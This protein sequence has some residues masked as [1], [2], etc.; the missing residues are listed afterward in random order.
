MH[1]IDRNLSQGIANQKMLL[2]SPIAKRNHCDCRV[3]Q[4]AWVV[5][6]FLE[7]LALIDSF[8]AVED[9]ESGSIHNSQ[10]ILPELFHPTLV[11]R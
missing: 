6:L 8:F 2:L 10:Q 9:V 4:Q 7:N 3:L 11:G 5:M 1:A